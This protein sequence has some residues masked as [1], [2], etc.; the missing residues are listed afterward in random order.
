MT[1]LSGTGVREAVVAGLRRTCFPEVPGSVR[2][3]SCLCH[4]SFFSFRWEMR[5]VDDQIRTERWFIDGVQHQ[6]RFTGGEWIVTTVNRSQPVDS[7]EE[8]PGPSRQ[9]FP[10]PLLVVGDIHCT[11]A[12]APPSS[13]RFVQIVRESAVGGCPD[14]AHRDVGFLPRKPRTKSFSIDSH[15]S[16]FHLL[17][18]APLGGRATAMPS[19]ATGGASG[20]S[21]RFGV[22]RETKHFIPFCHSGRP[23]R[24]GYF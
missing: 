23:A 8:R 9:W 14:M 12:H 11:T 15:V 3:V 2:R 18:P 6:E 7:L 24:E 17:H 16:R 22:R 21:G 4:G 5:Q 20:S 10:E 19:R 1:K 13:P